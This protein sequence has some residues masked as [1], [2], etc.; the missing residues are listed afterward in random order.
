[1][2]INKFFTHSVLSLSVALLLS[3]CG[4]DDK[5]ST[6]TALTPPTSST[7]D[8]PTITLN[9]DAN[10]SLIVGD[11]FRDLNATASDPI[12]VESDLD[13]SKAGIY[14]ITYTTT[15]SNGQ[16]ASVKRV[17]TVSPAPSVEGT[18]PIDS[19]IEL[20]GE[21]GILYYADPRPEEN[22]QN[23]AL[24]IDYNN[25]TFT[26]IS[27]NGINPHSI[28]RAGETDKF[29]IRT[30]NSYSF[31][32]VNFKTGEVRTIDLDDHKPRAI[33]AYNKKYNLQLLSAKDMPIVDVIDVNNDR[34]IATLGDRNTYDKSQLTSNAGAG[35]ATGHAMWLDEDHFILIDRVHYD[36]LVYKVIEN[37]DGSRGFERTSM[38]H[39]G[40]ALHA[41]KRVAQPQTR[42]DLTTFYALGEGDLTKG[43]APFVLE[44]SFDPKTGVLSRTKRADGKDRIAY[45]S[46]S[47]EKIDNV[48]PTTHHAGIT[49]DGKYF[50][51]PVFDGKV[52][53]IN[54]ETMETEKI[55]Q[56]KLGAAHIEFSKPLD[57]AIVTNHFA[58]ELTIIDLKTLSVK[59]QLF[60][61]EHSFDPNNNHLLQPHF[62]YLSP[63][64]KY[65][66]TF[67]TQDGDFLKIN[68]ETLEIEDRLH[69]G[70]APEQAHS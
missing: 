45:L 3:A 36:V 39:A 47:M 5:M 10:V 26:D 23:R 52:Y 46:E 63:D 1:M 34:V 11:T 6:Q 35:S 2:L 48:N 29:Y 40:T 18:I 69:T 58:Q 68:L 16:K 21:S 8:N 22:G 44:L 54:R 32:V 64:G 59:K 55:V 30:Q 53:F 19:N 62:S 65:F 13:T 20:G 49:P 25:M 51:A 33:G 15:D 24:R 9:G 7:N 67:A 56:A 38:V 14:T 4:D 43:Y 12:T 61:S 28:D 70:G 17:I 37:S 42:K 50:V 27:V 57:L 31:D 66:Y 41:I 60:I